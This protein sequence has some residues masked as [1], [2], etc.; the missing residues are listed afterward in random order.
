MPAGIQ[1]DLVK[2]AKFL[3]KSPVFMYGTESAPIRIHSSDRSG[4]GF[5]VIGADEKSVM[6]YV[7]FDQLNTLDYKGWKLTGAV[8]FYESDVEI[9]H[10]SFINNLCEDALNTIR[11]HFDYRNS[12]ISQ[13]L[14]D[15]FDA[16]F[17]TGDI[18]D[19]R[20]SNT[21]NDGMDFSGSVIRVHSAYVES[22][23]DKGL[24]V[25]EEATVSV[26]YLEVNGAP[27]GVASKDL[28]RLSIGYIKLKNCNTGFA[29][30]QKKP[31]YGSAYISVDKYEA[32]NVRHLHLIEKGSV[33]ELVGKEA[34]GI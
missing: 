32:E 9:D 7:V 20:F 23:G 15:G 1:I 24:S 3:S 29:A 14:S 6:H 17:C 2:K 33:L 4:N 30:Y 18:W 27:T 22:A 12:L 34:E 26:D 31:E 19:A 11:C 13:T 16:D 21:G 5:T 25:G 10:C 8:T 28:S